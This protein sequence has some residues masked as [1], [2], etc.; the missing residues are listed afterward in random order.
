MKLHGQVCTKKV[1][2]DD[3]VTKQQTEL[4]TNTK[5]IFMYISV[6]QLFQYLKQ[7]SRVNGLQRPTNYFIL[8]I[9]FFLKI[10]FQTLCYCQMT[11]NQHSK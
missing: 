7:S 10:K 4:L 11:H 9:I 8:L 1:E 6:C 2:N 3:N 5:Y